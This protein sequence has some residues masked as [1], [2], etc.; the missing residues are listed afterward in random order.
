MDMGTQNANE[1]PGEMRSG[2]IYDP[3]E[4]EQL[5][6]NATMRM[7]TNN[8][9]HKNK[10]SDSARKMRKNESE[11]TLNDDTRNWKMNVLI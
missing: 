5:Q 1:T 3:Q 7:D 2:S 4:E 9:E 10:Q 11:S 8:T 6:M